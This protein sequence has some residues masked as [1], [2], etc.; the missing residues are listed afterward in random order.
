[1]KTFEAP[2]DVPETAGSGGSLLV[3]V[4]ATC[5]LVPLLNALP[6]SVITWRAHN[7]LVAESAS[8]DQSFDP[9]VVEHGVVSAGP[10]IV[11]QADPRQTLLVDPAETVPDS[12]VTTP[13]FVIVR[14]TTITRKDAVRTQ[15]WQVSELMNLL[16]LTSVTIDSAHMAEAL[17]AYR[18][19]FYGFM[20]LVY[21]IQSI[22]D[23]VFIGLYALGVAALLALAL[24]GR[25]VSFRAALGP[26]LLA[27]VVTV[28]MS[29][30]CWA[31]SLPVGWIGFLVWPC[32]MFAISV[33]WLVLTRR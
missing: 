14:S 20:A 15:S 23:I 28:P 26:T 6:G 9:I 25:G 7:R 12:E 17:N 8:Y 32:T 27:G 5:L 18:W 2:A 31:V 19:H 11:Y 33:T 21:L 22:R 1:M 30:A 13:E 24:R 4:L 16:G 29:W 3:A 10:R